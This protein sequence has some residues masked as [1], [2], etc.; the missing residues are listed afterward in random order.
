MA[1]VPPLDRTPP[2]WAK[3]EHLHRVLYRPQLA[4]IGISGCVG[5]GIFVTS[6]SLVSTTGSLGAAISYVIAGGIVACVCYT[7]TE[8]LSARPLTGALI[9]FPH[10]FLDP[11]CGFAVALSYTLANICSMAT[12]TAQSAELTAQLKQDPKPHPIEVEAAI[13]VALIVLTTFSHCLGVILYG[14]IERIIM[15][16]KLCLLVLVCILMIVVNTGA[17][18][19]RT[20]SY[21]ANYTSHAFTPGWKPTGYANVTESS[22]SISGVSDGHF[23][24]DGSGGRFFAF[25]T[26]VTL[27][28]FSCMGGDYMA[29]TAGEAKNPY[30][31]VPAA[32]SFVYL[33]PLSSYPLAMMAASANVNYADENLAKIY[34]RG[35]GPYG[36][37]PLSPFVIAVQSTSL[38][39]LPKALNLF[40]II[41]S[42][43][44]ANSALYVSSRTFFVLAQQY[45]PTKFANIFGRTNRG[46]TPLASILFCSA[47]GFLSL[48]GLSQ[49]AYSQ[50]RIT[51]SE[52]YTGAMGSVYLIQCVSFLNYKAGLD[53][54]AKNKIR[55]RKGEIHVLSRNDDLYISRLFKSRWQPLPAWIGIIGS[56]FVIVWSGI[57]PLFILAAKGS[58]TST[59]GLKSTTALA[60]DVIGVYVGPVFFAICYFAYKRRTGC[61][62]IDIND[63]TP[64]QY[65]L[66]DLEF[67]E[68][69]VPGP[70]PTP[71]KHSDASDIG[72]IELNSP[73]DE[74]RMS[75]IKGKNPIRHGHSTSVEIGEMTADMRDQLEAQRAMEAEKKRVEDILMR[76]PKRMQNGI[77]KEIWS[78]VVTTDKE[79]KP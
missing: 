68:S 48:I 32:M 51:L 53:R 44:A 23:G 28:M 12:L 13:N 45:L 33:V 39:G 11:A 22:L 15:W 46:N 47:L 70:P 8:M 50:P 20:E 43:T 4:G 26:A 14:K 52:F 29:V 19:P 76:R 37:H 65:V 77:W 75:T 72:A 67:L 38:H 3:H 58:L 35:G 64:S 78:F 27:S 73:D 54:I 49:Y 18:G 79:E 21:K 9:D 59:S 61:E 17:V 25:L 1:S 57:P 63:L 34:S 55:V 6:G 56:G 41:S 7:I 2:T 42:Y 31:D 30:K 36:P 40:F 5:A 62:R 71:R 24:L 66:E 10:T 74:R 60:F 69:S 16:F